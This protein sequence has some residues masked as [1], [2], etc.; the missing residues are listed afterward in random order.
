MPPK[1][2]TSETIQLFNGKNL[3]GWE[4]HE[5]YWSVQDGVIVGKNTD[6]VKVSTYLLTKRNFTDFRLLATVKLVESKCTRASPC[7]DAVAPEHGDPYTYRRPPGDVSHRL[8]HVR[9][10]TAATD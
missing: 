7:G 2:G 4:G 6:P 9:S 1:T 5:K 3:D 10:V 8:G